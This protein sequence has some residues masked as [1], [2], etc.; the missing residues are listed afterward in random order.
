MAVSKA[1][2]QAS[3]PKAP[4][5]QADGR[6]STVEKER[7][8][9]AKPVATSDKKATATESAR[10]PRFFVRLDLDDQQRAKIQAIQDRY[11]V[12]LKNLRQQIDSLRAD[13][14][15]QIHAVLTA[16]QLKKLNEIKASSSQ[17]SSAKT[18]TTMSKKSTRSSAITKTNKASGA[19]AS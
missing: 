19:K 12:K 13:W 9:A 5:R 4:S 8:L 2:A 10:L 18:K 6:T 1:L 14:D 17:S 3:K 11:E 16:A 7:P 15:S